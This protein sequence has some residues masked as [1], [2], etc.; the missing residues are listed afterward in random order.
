MNKD[1]NNKSFVPVDFTKKW[2]GRA[3]LLV[4]LDA[5]FAS[6]EQLDHP[7]WR[8]KP[9]IVGGSAE[10]GGVVSTCSYEAREFGVRSAQPS[11]IAK[12][13]CPDA[14]WTFGNFGRYKEV[15]EQIMQIL[16]DETPFVEQVS[17]DEAFMDVTPTRVNTE[18][19][20][21]IA[22][23]IQKRVENLGVTCSIGVGTSK[24]IAKVASDI[25]KPRGLTVVFPGSER[26]FLNP[27]SIR[28]MSGI[29]KKSEKL[30]NEY[31]I[32]TLK[33]LAEADVAILKK[34]FGINAT[35]MQDRALGKNDSDVNPIHIIKS[36]SNESTFPIPLSKET[37]IKSAIKTLADNVCRRLRKKHLK[38]TTVT[39]RIKYLNM[40]SRTAQC[41]VMPTDNE[42][43]LYPALF[44]LL[45]DVW[46]EG[47]SVKLLGVGVSS[48]NIEDQTAD[49]LFDLYNADIT[50]KQ[51]KL[52]INTKKIHKHVRLTAATDVLKDKYGEDSI[53][54]GHELRN[55]E[56]TTHSSSKNP[57]DY[58]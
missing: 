43:Q 9:V 10:N 16:Y 21:D 22:K 6:V 51:Q 31:G 42:M 53:K 19:P 52:E 28:K 3:I 57:A 40:H 23:R 24:S 32:Y 29:G 15:S 14:I 48:F 2:Q 56:N 54:Y 36:I 4:D 8:G 33:D 18:H 20:A 27:L 30:L 39:L 44:V 58:R 50:S 37:E 34:V 46:H 38:G 1:A 17:I 5:F 35:M 45:D 47:I 55:K 11:A 25:D 26:A 41:K 7:D 49:T 12:Q 13:L